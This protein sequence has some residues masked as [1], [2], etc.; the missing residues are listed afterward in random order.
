[1]LVREKV[2]GREHVRQQCQ[3]HQVWEPGL[4]HCGSEGR[5]GR[6]ALAENTREQGAELSPPPEPWQAASEPT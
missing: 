3:G 4:F 1:M 5:K 6:L 2:A